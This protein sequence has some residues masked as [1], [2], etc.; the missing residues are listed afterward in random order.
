MSEPAFR[1]HGATNSVSYEARRRIDDARKRDF[2]FY[3]RSDLGRSDLPR[4][5]AES[6]AAVVINGLDLHEKVDRQYVIEKLVGM[7]RSRH[8]AETLSSVLFK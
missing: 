1:E 4:E 6:L 2:V 3:L 7:G 5:D 8:K